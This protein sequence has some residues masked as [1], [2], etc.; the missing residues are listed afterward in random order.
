MPKA[1][2]PLAPRH[3]LEELLLR[4]EKLLA[5]QLD[6]L[7]LLSGKIEHNPPKH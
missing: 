2:R 7:N 5:E 4:Q 3:L 1:K 6:Y